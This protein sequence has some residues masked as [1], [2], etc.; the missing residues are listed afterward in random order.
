MSM[1]NL[2]TSAILVIYYT[3]EA[4]KLYSSHNFIYKVRYLDI[5]NVN[6]ADRGKQTVPR[7][8][9]YKHFSTYY[10]FSED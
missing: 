2:I 8:I 5:T 10:R 6:I 4:G 7:D 1:K 3:V 9:Y